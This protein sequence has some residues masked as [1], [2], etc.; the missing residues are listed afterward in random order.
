MT[1]M[2]YALRKRSKSPNTPVD[3]DITALPLLCRV[4]QELGAGGTFAIGLDER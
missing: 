3:A 4:E 1:A 2:I